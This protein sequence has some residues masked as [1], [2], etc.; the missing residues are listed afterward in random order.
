MKNKNKQTKNWEVTAPGV[1]AWIIVLISCSIQ[2]Q[3]SEPAEVNF[4]LAA[5]F[6]A[7]TIGAPALHAD[8]N[9]QFNHLIITARRS[10]YTDSLLVGEVKYNELAILV[11]YSSRKPV[12]HV[13]IAAG[14]ARFTGYRYETVPGLFFW[15]RRTSI[16]PAPA[17]VIESQIFW[18]RNNILGIGLIPYINLNKEQS[19]VS[20]TVCFILGKLN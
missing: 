2:A 5:G 11:G 4:W 16:K 1:M 17:L 3:T 15:G 19:F 8:F 6:G 12:Y 7:S 14:L 20:L 18:K 10:F 13:S 9:L